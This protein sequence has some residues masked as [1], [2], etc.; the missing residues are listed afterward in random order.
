[1]DFSEVVRSAIEAIKINK[2]RSALTALG[3]II[4]VAAII[5]L[6][7]ISAGLQKYISGQFEKLGTNSIFI[8]PGKFRPGPQ[9]GPPRAVN[10]L[11][12]KIAE[13]IEKQKNEAII[14][15]S[16]F[17]EID[18]TVSYKNKSK[19]TTLAGVKPTYFVLSDIGAQTGRTFTDRE[20]QVEAKMA[21]VGQTIAKDLYQQENPVGKVILISKKSYRVLGV[22]EPQGRAGGIDID[23]QVLIPLNSARKLTGTDQVNSILVRTSSAETIP[24]AKERVEKILKQSLSEDEFSIL[25]QEQLLSSILQIIGVLTVALGGIA[26]ISLIVGGV[27][28]SNI[29]LVSVTERTREIGLRKALGARP[30]DILSQFLTEAVILSFLGG[31]IGVLIGYLGSL[32]LSNFLQT[33][34]PFWAVALGLGFSTV[35][36]VIFGVAPALRAAR[37]QPV[38]ALRH[39]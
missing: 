29:M 27:G 3:V 5:L 16:P 32:V 38:E 35:V 18:V 33:F 6:I 22:L 10:K 15:V 14:D 17:V 4:G 28:I 39:E 36:G 31:A 1:M 13:R 8:L 37:L 12:F 7:S 19:I 25:T 9:G 21:V 11:T 23:N 30:R 34:V 24:Q 26:A 2:L 20:N